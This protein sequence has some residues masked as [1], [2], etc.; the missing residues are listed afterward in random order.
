MPIFIG[1]REK[2]LFNRI[3]NELTKNIVPITVKYLKRKPIEDTEDDNVYGEN[4]DAP[5]R[6]METSESFDILAIVRMV[7]PQI[8]EETTGIRA[9]RTVE[10]WITKA[11]LDKY[12]IGEPRVGDYL[13]YWNEYWDIAK[14]NYANMLNNNPNETFNYV[15]IA[16]L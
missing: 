1:D 8:I 11:E 3:H 16:S 4:R 10:V 15:L 9:Q 6:T 12:N 14:V 7:D 2:K 13:Y 5:T